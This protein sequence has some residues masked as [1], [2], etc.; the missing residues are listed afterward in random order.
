MGSTYNPLYALQGIQ[1]RIVSVMA[2]RLPTSDDTQ[3]FLG[4]AQFYK[5]MTEELMRNYQYR[6]QSGEI[7]PP[8]RTSE[9]RS[10]TVTPFTK[11]PG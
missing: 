10:E 3:Y 1:S 6:V 8:A 2:V 5:L 11:R 9:L 4:M 7:V